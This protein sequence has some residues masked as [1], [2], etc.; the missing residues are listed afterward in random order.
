MCLMFYYRFWVPRERNDHL[1][2]QVVFFFCDFFTRLYGGKTARRYVP[3]GAN[4]SINCLH[5]EGAL[6][7]ELLASQF[8]HVPLSPLPQQ[9]ASLCGFVRPMLL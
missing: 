6:V 9:H 8:G 1:H 7:V 2:C 5:A 3:V 4:S